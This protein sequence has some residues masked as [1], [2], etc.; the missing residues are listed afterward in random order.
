MVRNPVNGNESILTSFPFVTWSSSIWFAPTLWAIE[1]TSTPSHSRTIKFFETWK[2]GFLI[3]TN[4]VLD[5]YFTSTF[6]W[7]SWTIDICGR[8]ESE[9]GDNNYVNEQPPHSVPSD[10]RGKN[11]ERFSPLAVNKI[12]GSHQGIPWMNTF[13]TNGA[14]RVLWLL[15][16]RRLHEESW[17]FMEK[18]TRKEHIKYIF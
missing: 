15:E 7:D 1:E 5:S 14:D 6:L 8:C 13:R 11:S 18:V 4:W 2:I 16:I 9:V 17:R 3:W 12:G 10:G